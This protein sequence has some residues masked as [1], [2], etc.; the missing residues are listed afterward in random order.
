LD[1][2]ALV[3]RFR[4]GDMQAFGL[5]VAK[6][7]DRIYGL[8]LRMCPRP[9]DAEELAQ[10]A[11]LKAMERIGQFRGQS[12]FYTWLFR[13]AANLAISLRRRVGRLKFQSLTGSDDFENTQA[14]AL[15]AALAEQRSPSPVAAAISSESALRIERAMASLDEEF[16]VVL[17]LRDVEELDYA[18]IADVLD[19][20]V[21]TVKSRLHRA[22]MILRDMLGDLLG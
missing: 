9:A 21:G 15:T 6:Y 5:L 8:V 16:R 4:K 3:E 13:I 11:F 10:E 18:Q 2:T 7:Q 14:E 20:P 17:V 22:R 19:L 1:D 12:Q